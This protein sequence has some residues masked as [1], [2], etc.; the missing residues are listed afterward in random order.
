M[1]PVQAAYLQECL[2]ISLR[3]VSTRKQTEFL[4]M[5]HVQLTSA[6][7]QLYT[8]ASALTL[9]FLVDVPLSVATKARSQ[10]RTFLDAVNECKVHH[11]HHHHHHHQSS[12]RQ[13]D[14][15]LANIVQT[16]M[17][18]MHFVKALLL[19]TAPDDTLC[20]AW[21][22]TLVALLL[23]RFYSACLF[24]FLVLLG[25]SLCFVF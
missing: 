1:D 7:S 11:H 4:H 23:V 22:N 15:R 6:V 5:L 18:R 12:T 10:Q 16:I 13:D 24:F 19:F 25:G 9:M 8:S 17:Q 2:E 20:V 21:I 3:A 14:P